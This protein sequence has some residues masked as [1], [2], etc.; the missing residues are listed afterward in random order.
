[1][2]SYFSKH[3]S[4]M[5][6]PKESES[7][8]GLRNA[9]IGAIHAISSFFT[10]NKKKAAIIVM[11]TGS[12]KTSVLMMSPYI[13]ESK[14]V[15]VITPSVLVRGQIVE[16]FSDLITLCKANVFQNSVAKPNVFELKNKYSDELS[17]KIIKADIVVTTP[18][19]ALSLSRTENIKDLFDLVLVDE[20]HHSPAATW[21]ETLVNIGSAKHVLFTATPFRLDRKEIRG[22]IIYSYPLSMAYRDGI[23]GEIQYI[24]LGITVN[25]DI[26]IAELAEKVFVSDKEKGFNHFIM[27]RTSSKKHAEE[28]SKIYSENTQLKLK[29]IDS[30]MT[31]SSVKNVIEELKS[32]NLDGIICVD[33]LGE[34]FDF[35]NLKIAAIHSPHK[36]LANTLQFIGRF[37]RTN[38]ENIGTAKFIAMNDEE[39]VIENNKLYS[40]DAVWQDMIIDMSE[41]KSRSEEIIKQYFNNFED[42]NKLS[43]FADDFSLHNLHP[44]CHAKVYEVSNFDLYANFPSICKTI[45]A[46][47]VNKNDN[48]V[49]VIG[50][51]YI[52][53]K[54]SC[55]ED[56]YDMNYLLF[57]IHFQQSTNLL[58]IY[59]E[60]KSEFVY[61]QIVEAY[62]N[63]YSKVPKS[64]IHR[65]LGELNSFE[66]FNSGMLNRYSKS[67]ETYRILAGP[68]VSKAIDPTTGKMFSPGHVFC[69]AQGADSIVTIG[70]SSGSKI[71]SSAYLL[72]PE[73]IQWCDYNGTKIANQNIIVKTNTN[74]DLL[75]VPKLL[76]QYPD[77]IFMWDFL[78]DTY[79][80]PPVILEQ[81]GNYKSTLLDT[82]IKIQSVNP[83]AV[84]LLVSF[85]NIQEEIICDNNG[86]YSSENQRITVKEGRREISL[87][88][89]FNRNPLGFR[90]SDDSLI[91]GNEVNIGDPNAIVFDKSTI[92]GIKW[93]NYNTDIKQEISGNNSIQVT[94]RK[95][96][97]ENKNFSYIIY[98]HSSGEM[99]DFIT[100]E[101]TATSIEVSFYHVKGMSATNY[102]S[103]VSDV[104]EVAG[105]AVKSLIWLKNKQT[106]INKMGQR[107]QSG[108]CK[109]EIGKHKDFLATV[110]QYKPLVGKIIVVQPA[111]SRSI[112]MPEKIQ[113]VLGAARYYI[114][115]SGSVVSFDIW[116]SE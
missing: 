65:V 115:N 100:V 42:T 24:P 109:F 78:G 35:P 56:L 25:K 4:T 9:Q 96:L 60:M 46:T 28:L 13:L 82:D 67:G 23:F 70:Y 58:F 27:V 51:E 98:D 85:D 22:D 108:K 69:K 113:E 10:L 5:K 52:S 62:C 38:A 41:N 91:V 72:I 112:A 68:D 110:K 87:S 73:Y 88:E 48:T 63:T 54:W 29:K 50:K 94:L 19:C 15:L 107:R 77:N 49:I 79:I 17:D 101:E 89:Y 74:Y 40:A 31:N 104:Y 37:A 36:S 12:G 64:E 102:N 61:E 103:S 39:L 1:V 16:E 92:T 75:P 83:T 55:S 34:G 30:S 21:E 76:D 66:I 43:T 86:V 33:M 8:R 45:E 116:G 71:W 18:I 105:Q 32:G 80:T 3:Y 6:Y 20:A 93:G 59:S 106:L 7:K 81:E 2:K 11:P 90:T 114:I 44:N 57:I 111:I 84:S 26:A 53:P 99:A 95:I 14:K 97:F 47:L